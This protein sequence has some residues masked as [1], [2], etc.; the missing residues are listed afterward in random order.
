MWDS[1]LGNNIKYAGNC[2]SVPCGINSNEEA[3]EQLPLAC[4]SS[5]CT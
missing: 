4:T 1:L 5:H 3:R 2:L